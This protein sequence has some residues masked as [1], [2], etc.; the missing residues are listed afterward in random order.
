MSRKSKTEE[1]NKRDNDKNFELARLEAEKLRRQQ[2]LNAQETKPLLKH[3]VNIKPQSPQDNHWRDV[4]K[5]YKKKFPEL[6]IAKDGTLTFPD[7]KSAEQFFTEQAKNHEFLATWVVDGKMQD[8][9]FYSCGNGKLYVGS[10]AEILATLNQD[11]KAETDTKMKNKL[12]H[13]I[14]HLKSFMP[15][16]ANPAFEMRSKLQESK[17]G[18]ESDTPEETPSPKKTTQHKR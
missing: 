15:Q 14:A 12:T 8:D 17:R 6:E 18:T 9:H 16:E 1:Q 13:G 2:E 7:R 3:E 4:I 10:F 5:N 11:L